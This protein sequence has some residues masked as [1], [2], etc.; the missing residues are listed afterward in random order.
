MK[1]LRRQPPPPLIEI[2]GPREDGLYEVYVPRIDRLNKGQQQALGFG[3]YERH[4]GNSVY[5]YI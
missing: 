2:S 1:E 3:P 5:I 4:T